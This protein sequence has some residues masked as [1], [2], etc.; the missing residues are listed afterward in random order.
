MEADLL[1]PQP[2]AREDLVAVDMEPLRRDVDVDPAFAVGH[3]QPR[4]R[5]EE[6]L[7]LGA[8]LVDARHRHVAFRVR[9][10]AADDDRTHDVRPVVLEITVGGRR[11][12]GVE[13]LLL[14]R[15][16]RVE[17]RIE[18][19]VLHL[20]QVGCSSRLLRALRR[21]ERYR[22]AEVADAVDREHRLVG[23]LEAVG[24]AAGHVVVREHGV[25]TR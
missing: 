2:E 4:L 15:A 8:R 22:L 23:K 16:L 25:D 18:E 9:V 11:T 21:D 17:D 6:G 1:G 5:A 7:I 10:A 24:L 14:R 13:R 19:R 12:L 3:G 20:D